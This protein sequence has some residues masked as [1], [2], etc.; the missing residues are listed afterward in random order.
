MERAPTRFRTETYQRPPC[1]RQ[2]AP[3]KELL[4][5]AGR[6]TKASKG[7]L[8]CLPLAA[9]EQPRHLG[10]AV[11]GFADRDFQ[12]VAVGGFV[13]PVLARHGNLLCSIVGSGNFKFYFDA[14]R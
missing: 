5:A 11:A 1:C 12:L 8:V 3:G 6:R 7:A 10:V 9:I 4:E 2:S 13:P 14:R